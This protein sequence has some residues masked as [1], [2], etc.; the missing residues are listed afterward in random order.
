MSK[1]DSPLRRNLKP[2]HILM[3]AL[4]GTIGS[5]IFQGSSSSIHLAGPGVLV[6]YLVGGLILLVVMRGL[7][8]MAVDNPHATTIKGLIDPILGHFT[9]YV[10]GWIY[11]LDWVLVMAAETAAAST[12]LQFW[13]PSV[14]LWVLAL[15][16]SVGMTI[17]NLT[18][19]RVFGETEY[20]LAGVKILTLSLFVIFGAVLLATRYSKHQVANNLF[21]HGGFFPHGIGGVAA[22]MLVV[23]FSF[24]GIEM[25]GMTLGETEDP[26]RT[27]PR[28][29]RSVIVRILLFYLLPIAVIV[30][31]VPWSQLGSTQSPFVTVFTQIGIPYVGSIMNFVM[32]TAVLSAVNTGMYATSRMMFTQ[33]M[34]GNAPKLFCKVTKGNVPVRALLFSTVFL[35]IGVVV[36]FFAKGNTFN[37]LM[38]I[39]GYTVMMVWMFLL[40]SHW[41]QHGPKP[42][43]ILALAALIAIFVAVVVTSP[44]AGTIVSLVAVGV[45]AGSYLFARR[46]DKH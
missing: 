36:A 14:P 11:W 35:Y 20:W 6:T 2:R 43:T 40:A 25:I 3:M 24:G 33:A 10:S 12:F 19:V 21:G 39:P 1:P 30:S 18:P 22:A 45:I 29:A 28:A 26:T 23:M 34:D 7:A 27:I 13:F 5:G 8:A 17:L 15:L 16:I 46:A 38:V 9:G 32:L 41:K 37:D 4:G 42:T 44:V 31:L